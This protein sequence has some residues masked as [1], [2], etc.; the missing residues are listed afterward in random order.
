ME[1]SAV[2]ESRFD[3]R[4]ALSQLV[5]ILFPSRKVAITR[6]EVYPKFTHHVP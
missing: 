5:A 6:P 4:I 3:I 2:S 1:T